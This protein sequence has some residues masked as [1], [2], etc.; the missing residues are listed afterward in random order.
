M[1]TPT[2][3]SYLNR[4]TH[5]DSFV[6][7]ALPHGEQQNG[8]VVSVHAFFRSVN[9]PCVETVHQSKWGCHNR[10][11][12]EGMQEGRGG[13]EDGGWNAVS[14]CLVF[15]MDCNGE[16]VLTIIN[17]PLFQQVALTVTCGSSKDAAA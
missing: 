8:A 16:G 6:A 12:A 1:A 13:G 2:V 11:P 17:H 9:E 3:I 4:G 14:G 7:E 5:L 10:V 15:Q